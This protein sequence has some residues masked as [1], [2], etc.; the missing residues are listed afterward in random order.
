M[1]YSSGVNIQNTLEDISNLEEPLVLENKVKSTL[2]SLRSWKTTG[3]DEMST[4][5]W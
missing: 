4:K 3:T 2:Q 5:I 1:L